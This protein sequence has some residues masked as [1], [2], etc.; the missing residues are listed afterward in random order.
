[1][2]CELGSPLSLT[3][4]LP[5]ALLSFRF[6]Y[7]ETE[8]QRQKPTCRTSQS[9]EDSGISALP[10]AA[11]LATQS[12]EALEWEQRVK[13]LRARGGTRILESSARELNPGSATRS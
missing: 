12:I 10:L 11:F 9:W 2:P 8:I 7:E 1:M 13:I 3:A 4:S 5:Q 6:A